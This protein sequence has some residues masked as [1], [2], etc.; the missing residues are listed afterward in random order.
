MPSRIAMGATSW[1]EPLV[2]VALTLAAIAGLV[3]FGARVYAGAVLQT[4]PTLKLRQAWRTA[5]AAAPSP[6]GPTGQ[7]DTEAR[8]SGLPPRPAT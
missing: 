2:A 8:G 3:A 5:T 6:A 1:W 7:T 4:G